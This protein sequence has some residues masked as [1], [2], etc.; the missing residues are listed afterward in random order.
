MARILGFRPGSIPGVGEHL[1]LLCLTFFLLHFFLFIS[2]LFCLTFLG[3]LT[4]LCN[5]I[6][7]LQSVYWLQIIYSMHWNHYHTVYN[8]RSMSNNSRHTSSNKPT[9]VQC[10][11][12]SNVLLMIYVR[13][14]ES[15]HN[16]YHIYSWNMPERVWVEFQGD[17]FDFP[18]SPITVMGCWQCLPLS[19][20]QLKGKHCPKR[21]YCT[22]VVDKF[23]LCIVL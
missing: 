6:I 20:I 9:T 14:F 22:G 19:V 16:F 13:C 8:Y 7:E 2:C 23:G 18:Q 21:H 5:I 12:Q 15:G 3:L 17:F 4:E 11:I 1:F 10:G